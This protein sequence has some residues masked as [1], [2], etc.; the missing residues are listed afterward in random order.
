MTLSN[1]FKNLRTTKFQRNFGVFRNSIPHILSPCSRMNRKVILSCVIKKKD[2]SQFL[3]ELSDYIVYAPHQNGDN[4][5]FKSTKNMDEILFQFTNSVKSPKHVLLPQTETLLKITKNEN[6]IK[7][8]EP[9]IDDKSIV[10][11]I[12]PCDAKGITILD[13]IFSGDFEDPYYFR[14]RGNTVLIGFAC[15][16]PHRNC[17]CTSVGCAPNSTDGV[18]MLWT[19]LED[20]YYVEVLTEKGKKIIEK[21]NLFSKASK[22]DNVEKDKMHKNAIEMIAE[23][24]ADAMSGKLNKMFED[25]Y[26]ENLSLKCLGCGVCTYLCPTCYCFDINDIDYGNSVKRVRTWDSCQYPSYTIHTSGHNPRP[27]KVNRL[28]NRIYHKYRYHLDNYKEIACVGCGRCI[29]YCP[30]NMDLK[31]IIKEVGGG[32]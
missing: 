3:K 11:G 22:K 15:N 7:I 5:L 21:M 31:A 9:E 13:R 1:N 29:T 19:D 27:N 26:W 28:R 10:F 32:L 17:F 16:E 6:E 23:V 8:D 18:D 25:E 14:R 30:V 20:R 4:V 2:V 24:N 12:R